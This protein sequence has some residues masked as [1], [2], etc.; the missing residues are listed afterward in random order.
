V[1]VGDNVEIGAHGIL[2]MGAMIKKG[3]TVGDGC[4]LGWPRLYH[5]DIPSKTVFDLRYDEPI[6]VYPGT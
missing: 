2:R 1:Q 6:Y 5:E 3:T 4:E